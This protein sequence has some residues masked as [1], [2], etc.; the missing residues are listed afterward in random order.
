MVMDFLRSC[1][2]TSCQ[3]TEDPSIVATLKWYWADPGATV[4]P[5]ISAF[6]SLNWTDRKVGYVGPGEILGSP[7]PYSKGAIV[8][9]PGGIHYDGTASWFEHGQPPGSPGLIRSASGIPLD[10]S[11]PNRCLTIPEYKPHA[12]VIGGL[13][14][15]L[16]GHTFPPPDYEAVIG[17]REYLWG[18]YGSPAGM[19]YSVGGFG[20]YGFS[21]YDPVTLIWSY[22]APA[23]AP[24]PEGTV[25]SVQPVP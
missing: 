9:R 20:F 4:F 16:L 25:V 7:R 8:G 12:R 24:D 18:C 13:G 5:G 1:Y 3:F 23:G 2:S 17:G 21:G 14:A 19:M 11:P 10:C 15:G 6:G 22:V